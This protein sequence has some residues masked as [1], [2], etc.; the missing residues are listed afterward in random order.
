MGQLQINLIGFKISYCWEMSSY[1]LSKKSIIEIYFGDCCTAVYFMLG[2][3]RYLRL[4]QMRWVFFF[5]K[6][7]TRSKIGLSAAQS[8]RIPVISNT[9]DHSDLLCECFPFLA[10]VC[11]SLLPVNGMRYA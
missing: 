5:G 9:R 7:N 11:Q 10:K 4:Q 8:L 3:I 2:V 1:F 6:R